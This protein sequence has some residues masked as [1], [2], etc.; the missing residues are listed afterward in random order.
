VLS[1]GSIP[2]SFMNL[3]ELSSRIRAARRAK[4]YTLDRVAELS[5]LAKGMIS[6]VENFRVTPSLP[7]LVRLSEALGIRLSD[8]FEG[9]DARPKLSIVRRGERREF[10]RDRE[11]SDIRYESLA[12]GRTDRRMDPFELRVPAQGGRSEEMAHEGEEFMVVLEGEVEFHFDGT[13]HGMQAG[14]SAYFDG[15]TPHRLANPGHR[16]ARVLCVFLGRPL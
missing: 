3:V 11:H 2:V 13:V 9:L 15:E 7:T 4:G 8:L 10:E 1:D 16:E 12:H 14:D 5:G 6:K